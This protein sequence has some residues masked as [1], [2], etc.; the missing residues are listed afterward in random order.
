MS[1]TDPTP[2]DPEFPRF[3][4]AVLYHREIHMAA[5]R[6]SA[7]RTKKRAGKRASGSR[8]A[9]A[10]SASKRRTKSAAK[11]SSG[12]NKKASGSKKRATRAARRTLKT[13]RT[14]GEKNWEALKSTTA[15]VV[16]GVKGTFGADDSPNGR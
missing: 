10:K 16:E 14:A 8:R 3:R 15:Q 5:T 6:K 7:K 4:A 9:G 11:K 12:S 2:G 1:V 13:V